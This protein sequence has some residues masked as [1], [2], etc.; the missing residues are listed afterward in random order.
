MRGEWL[1]LGEDARGVDTCVCV[2]VCG[3]CARGVCR[4]DCVC[5][6]NDE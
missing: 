5:A 3:E 1:L 2:C 4:G 6:E